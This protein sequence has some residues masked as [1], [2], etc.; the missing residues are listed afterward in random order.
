M[1]EIDAWMEILAHLIKEDPELH[2]ATV[3]LIEAAAHNTETKAQL[4][5][6]RMAKMMRKT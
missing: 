6:A 4:R 5:E 3:K 1:S 2:D